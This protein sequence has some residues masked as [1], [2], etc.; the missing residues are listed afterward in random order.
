M[1]ND[2][3]T[4]LEPL[5]ARDRARPFVDEASA[6]FFAE[7]SVATACRLYPEPVA[8]RVALAAAAFADPA[9][10][11][12]KR[13]HVLL[14]VALV[15]GR[16]LAAVDAAEYLRRR[17]A[18]PGTVES[19]QAEIELTGFQRRGEPWSEGRWWRL[20]AACRRANE[21]HEKA[22]VF[23][24]LFAVRQ[25]LALGGSDGFEGVP[26]RRNR[27]RGHAFTQDDERYRNEAGR[28]LDLVLPLL[29]ALAPL[30]SCRMMRVL[31]VLRGEGAETGPASPASPV[32]EP[33]A[34]EAPLDTADAGGAPTSLFLVEEHTGSALHHPVY[35]LR[36]THAQPILQGDIL[37]LRGEELEAA[38][39]PQDGEATPARASVRSVLT[40]SPIL[41]H[42][43]A[44][45]LPDGARRVAEIAFF[46]GRAGDRAA[47]YLG[48][49]NGE[50][51][52][53]PLTPADDDRLLARRTGRARPSPRA[54]V[55]DRD[56]AALW[57]AVDEA[58]DAFLRQRSAEKVYTRGAYVDRERIRQPI[59]QFLAAPTLRLAVVTGMA[60]AGKTAFLCGLAESW[61]SAG[62]LDLVLTV[63]AAELPPTRHDLEA[64]LMDRLGFEA[65]AMGLDPAGSGPVASFAA[66]AR[67]WQAQARDRR[68]GGGGAPRVVVLLD[69]VDR[70]RDPA[71]LFDSVVELAAACEPATDSVE[72]PAKFVLSIALPI[73]ETLTASLRPDLWIARWPT[74]AAGGIGFVIAEFGEDEAERAW[75]AHRACAGS[76]PLTAW[77]DLESSLRAAL[78][79]PLLLRLAAEAFS[80][81]DVPRGATELEVLALHAR[82]TIFE[83]PAR[84]H[85]ARMLVEKMCPAA[86]LPRRSVPVSDLVTEP[87][88]RDFLLRPDGPYHALL[89]R[90]VL[91]QTETRGSN[92][93][94]PPDPHVEFA[95]D[96]TLGYLLFALGRG[97][98]DAMSAQQLAK[99]F[100]SEA[101]QFAP[102]GYG[103]DLALRSMGET[104]R[105][106]FLVEQLRGEHATVVAAATA[107]LL[108]WLDTEEPLTPEDLER[109]AGL[110]AGASTIPAAFRDRIA[111]LLQSYREGLGVV[112]VAATSSE[113]KARRLLDVLVAKVA[114]KR[115]GV[116]DA[117]IV[118]VADALAARG[119][120]VLAGFL[121]QGLLDRGAVGPTAAR[122]RVLLGRALIRIGSAQAFLRAAALLAEAA[123]SVN[124][125]RA[126][127]EATLLRVEALHRVGRLAEALAL[128]DD[129]ALHVN[130]R[131]QAEDRVALQ[132]ARAAVLV[133]RDPDA[134]RPVLEEVAALEM[135]LPA[136]LRG[137]LAW[138]QGR[139][140]TTADGGDP[141]ERFDTAIQQFRTSGDIDLVAWVEASLLAWRM[142]PSDLARAREVQALARA[143][144]AREAL[145]Q[146]ELVVALLTA[147]T[148]EGKDTRA[149]VVTA[150]GSV[151][152]A[153][154]AGRLWALARALRPL[155]VC[156]SEHGWVDR[157]ARAVELQAELL[158]HLATTE[159]R[160]ARAEIANAGTNGF[161][162][163]TWAGRFDVACRMLDLARANEVPGEL[164][165]I[166]LM[167][168]WRLGVEAVLGRAE[169]GA[170]A[171]IK[172][173]QA[174]FEALRAARVAAEDSVPGTSLWNQISARHA[175]FA[176]AVGRPELVVAA[177]E[178]FDAEGKRGLEGTS[179]LVRA[180][181]AEALL[182]VVPVDL[183]RAGRLAQQARKTTTGLERARALQVCA[184][185][186]R[187]RAEGASDFQERMRQAQEADKCRAEA[188]LA[189]REALPTYFDGDDRSGIRAVWRIHPF[190]EDVLVGAG[191]VAAEAPEPAPSVSPA[192]PEV[193]LVARAPDGGRAMGRRAR[194]RRGGGGAEGA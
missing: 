166:S 135:E 178:A 66:L 13:F 88:L 44:E 40:L 126:Y 1:S 70:A 104:E 176:L 155:S 162:Y 184:R 124:D 145:Y 133:D 41:R 91:V 121:A 114:S 144:D 165:W 120:D 101:Q 105:Q 157:A 136:R 10:G 130:R 86:G 18:G 175:E 47:D 119:S 131:F 42:L 2:A 168:A 92:P 192:A 102:A 85:L 152:R 46:D 142:A 76:Q 49:R 138:M 125:Q 24:S 54:R 148:S 87:V 112:V 61:R 19:Q 129:E 185:I 146:A 23:P 134:T 60:G 99:R 16:L 89:D 37:L 80:G 193:P 39:P 28:L 141:T 58:T 55:L 63:A 177:L 95:F 35:S 151:E 3:A 90:H 65:S 96:A 83:D 123:S 34:G 106:A 183:E 67:A 9:C 78:R 27:L 172:A 25:E 187:L 81:Q 12:D 31:A 189:I 4:P 14:D 108:V 7:P 20:S 169:A 109:R 127:L 11:W 128:F 180:Y 26:A 113:K 100:A 75:E 62:G 72:A 15:A 116:P 167:D 93:W 118:E 163:N 191:L 103:L 132:L 53:V 77:R 43:A 181:L 57:E 74:A 171:R 147:S 170:E 48:S 188:G 56:A 59:E 38:A 30:A 32:D 150:F 194:A 68:P 36:V 110:D 73:L 149:G 139:L 179:A 117:R 115:A 5:P 173:A 174:A 64:A 6:R 29:G 21:K 82:R 33:S 107:R 8:D 190:V 69:G 111:D 158:R 156:A 182:H 164:A 17:G 186:A 51:R 160:N 94:D 52:R 154:A 50:R 22:L 97:G 98:R 159:G 161:D 84:Q 153:F 140:K 137:Q 122:A 71:T 79:S 45:I 143:V